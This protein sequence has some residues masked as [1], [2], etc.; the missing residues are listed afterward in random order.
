[1]TP[2]TAILGVIT[3]SLVSLAFGLGVT[4]LVFF[5]L[6][7]ENLRFSSELPELFRAVAMFWVLAGIAWIGFVQTLRHSRRRHA[8]LALLWVGI[9]LVGW[10]YWPR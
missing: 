10:Y 3:G 1:V 4:L 9:L 8:T 7:D 6:R 2:F 5:V